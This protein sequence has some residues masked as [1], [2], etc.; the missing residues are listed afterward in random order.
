MTP[1]RTPGAGAA[2]APRS[3]TG[4]KARRSTLRKLL[5]GGVANTQGEL[6]TLLAER[7]HPTTQ[8]TVSRD[9]K[10]LGAERVVGDDGTVGYRLTTR[11]RGGV[12]PDMI[13]GVEHNEAMVVIRT[14]IGRA[15]AVGLDL[16]ALG[17]PD[18]MGTVAGDDTVLVVPRSIHRTDALAD[19]IRQMAGL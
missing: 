12:S 6:C 19:A 3:I 15:Q 11:V 4:P 2:G 13:I 5:A 7:G 17:L 8:S 9:L 18:V 1:G 14:E 16:D 10:L